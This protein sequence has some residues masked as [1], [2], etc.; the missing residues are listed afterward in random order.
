MG[1]YRIKGNYKLG[2]DFL[3][4]AFVLTV[5]FLK[6]TPC[7]IKVVSIVLLV[8]VESILFEEKAF[9]PFVGLYLQAL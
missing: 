7:S 8:L 1:D 9:F 5:L 6:E 3:H 2:E 4:K